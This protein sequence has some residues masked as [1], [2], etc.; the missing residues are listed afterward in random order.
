MAIPAKTYLPLLSFPMLRR[1]GFYLSCSHA[2]YFSLSAKIIKIVLVIGALAGFIPTD[3]VTMPLNFTP[4]MLWIWALYV[5]QAVLFAIIC[6]RRFF[7][8]LCTIPG[9][10]LSAVTRLYLW[11]HNIIKDGSYYKKIEE[12]HVKYGTRPLSGLVASPNP[13]HRRSRRS[14]RPE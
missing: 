10:F 1:G 13:A 8:P 6:Y 9:P 4:S 11:Y 2:R 14:D 7:H 12:M 5:A 3:C